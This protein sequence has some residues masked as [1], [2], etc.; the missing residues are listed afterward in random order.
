LRQ[1]YI[2]MYI[3]FQ[4]EARV[5]QYCDYAMGWTIGVR[6][7]AGAE[8]VSCHYLVQTGSGAHPAS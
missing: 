3:Y 7:P 6:I 8:S 1:L 5:A 2:E 4:D